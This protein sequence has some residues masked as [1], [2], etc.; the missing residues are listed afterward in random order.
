MC[1]DKSFLSERWAEFRIAKQV[2]DDKVDPNE[3]IRW[4]Y[5]K[6]MQHRQPRYEKMANWGISVDAQDIEKVKTPMQF[7][8][9]I[10][11]SLSKN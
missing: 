11:K 1:Y 9:L 8:S 5:S 10:E 7:N 3:F 6:A 2:T 4:T